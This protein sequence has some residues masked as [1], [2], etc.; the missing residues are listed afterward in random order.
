MNTYTERKL[1]YNYLIGEMEFIDKSDTLII[2]NNNDIKSVIV[3]QDTFYCD[4]GYIL[5]IRDKYPKVGLKEYIEFMGINKKDSYGVISGT[6]ATFTLNALP[7]DGNYYKLNANRDL[8]F[9]R[10]KMYYISTFGDSFVLFNRRNL[11]KLYSKNRETIKSFL[12]TN[13]TK[14]DSEDDLLKLA[15]YLGSL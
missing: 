13:N 14:F 1:N 6:S 10:T 5:Q 2:K 15:E 7:T 8:K 3:D 11:F 4:N 9:Q 12:K